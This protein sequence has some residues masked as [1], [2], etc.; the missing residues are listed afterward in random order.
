MIANMAEKTGKPLEDWI[1]LAKASGHDK[2]GAVV[3]FLKSEHGMMHGFANLVAHK[4]LKSDAGS[5]T[6]EGQDLVAIQYGGAKAALKPIYDKIISGINNFGDDVEQAPK[7]AYVS[8][9]RKKQFAIIQPSTI[10]RVD[11]GINLQDHSPTERLEKSG[12]FNSMVSHRV[13]LQ[14]PEDVDA[15]LLGRL[16]SAYDSAS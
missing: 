1:K 15:E 6:D 12:S 14:N 8:V 5:A 2:H 16:K 13:R 3:K 10:T 9:R 11:V 4:T 7:K